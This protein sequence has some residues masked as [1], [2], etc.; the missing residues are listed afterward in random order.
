VKVLSRQ[1][2]IQVGGADLCQCLVIASRVHSVTKDSY[3][4]GI[5]TGALSAHDFL[6]KSYDRA[7]IFRGRDELINTKDQCRQYCYEYIQAWVAGVPRRIATIY[8]FG[9][10]TNYLQ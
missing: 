2:N 8:Q 7:A 5:Y 6:E 10:D 1:E 3:W 9:N 4:G